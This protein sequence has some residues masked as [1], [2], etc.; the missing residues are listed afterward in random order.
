M[1]FGIKKIK[2]GCLKSDIFAK[3]LFIML[4]ALFIF[5]CAPTKVEFKEINPVNDPVQTSQELNDY[6]K[7]TVQTVDISQVNQELNQSSVAFQIKLPNGQYLSD[8]KT[9][10]LVIYENG[11]PVI[12]FVLSKNTIETKQVVDIVF[13]VDVTGS[14]TPTIEDAK[15]RLVNFILKTRSLG[16]HTRMCLITFGD[17]IVQKCN[18]FYNNDP[19]DSSTSIEVEKL[20]NNIKSLKAAQGGHDPGGYDLD[21]NSM[22][23]LIEATKVDWAPNNQ[24]FVVLMTD[25]GF[26]YSPG[27]TGSIGS[28]APKFT[29]IQNALSSSQVKVFAATP[30]L[31]GYNLPFNSSINGITQQ[32]NGEW[33]NYKDLV[34]GKINF[35]TILT[36]ILN[37][38]NTTFVASYTSNNI[39]GLDPSLPLKNRKIEIKLANSIIGTIESVSLKSNLQDGAKTLT[40]EFELSTKKIKKD[41]VIVY[42]NNQLQNSGFSIL[43]DKKIVFTNPPSSDS[44][45]KCQFEFLNAKDSFQLKAV[46]LNP[47]ANLDKLKVLIND[48]I[49]SS[50]DYTINEN[51]INTDQRM[52]L[53][54]KETVLRSSDPYEI[55]KRNELQLR[56]KYDIKK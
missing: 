13:A 40:K 52:I 33:F 39:P 8:L 4:V 47:K 5:N 25:A 38:V 16:Y 19:S 28:N 51:S 27:N 37:S 41:S 43:D 53:T 23:A 1:E 26:L 30:S 6:I 29:D 15:V 32:T 44:K 35:D 31:A 14:M 18:K 55:I 9:N 54:L 49:V 42:V 48:R 46:A 36:R 2:Y 7:P 34:S 17:Y 10:E 22:G 12:P 50:N 20:I 21:E 11:K 3:N 45:I 56:V 24:R